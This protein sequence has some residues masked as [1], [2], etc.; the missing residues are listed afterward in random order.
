[1]ILL[2]AL[3]LLVWITHSH[4]PCWL[5]GAGESTSVR[6]HR[7]L[8]HWHV[9]WDGAHKCRSMDRH[10]RGDWVLR[11]VAPDWANTLFALDL[12][13]GSCLNFASRFQ[14]LIGL[15]QRV[16]CCLPGSGKFV[17]VTRYRG[18]GSAA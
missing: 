4:C 11:R 9:T 7:S 18:S 2:A 8:C 5:T 13:F 12:L 1:L 15:R 3:V 6:D 10:H 17:A 14:L 16:C